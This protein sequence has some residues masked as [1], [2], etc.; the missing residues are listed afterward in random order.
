MKE[1]PNYQGATFESAWAYM[2]ECNRYL[3]EKQAET[4]RQ[5]KETERYIKALQAE[6]NREIKEIGR[7]MKKLQ[8]LTGGIAN[9]NGEMAEEYFYRAF[10]R[11]KTFV[12]ETFDQCI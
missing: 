1:L 5:M 10:R 3:T 4:D 12:N 8:K 7:E 6:T 11:K 2:Q 9:N